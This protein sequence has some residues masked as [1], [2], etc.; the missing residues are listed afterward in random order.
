MN[1]Y[2]LG[3]VCLLIVICLATYT[4]KKYF[5]FVRESGKN[6]NRM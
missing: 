5:D 3:G 6:K 1:S 4:I 2:I